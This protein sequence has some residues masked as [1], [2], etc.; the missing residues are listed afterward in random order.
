[1]IENACCEF[2][3]EKTSERAGELRG[4]FLEI[5]PPRSLS[6]SI[7]L[8]LHFESLCSKVCKENIWHLGNGESK[9]LTAGVELEMWLIP[10]KKT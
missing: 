10:L 8:P 5:C 9:K 1:V 4:I 6:L 2:Q 7:S 3:H